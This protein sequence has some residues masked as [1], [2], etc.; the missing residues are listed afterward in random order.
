MNENMIEYRFMQKAG[1]LKN[2]WLY[3]QIINKKIQADIQATPPIFI[4]SS[5]CLPTKGPAKCLWINYEGRK[6]A[7]NK[8]KNWLG[9]DIGPFFKATVIRPKPFNI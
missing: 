8:N 1:I 6:V 7:L 3:F 4:K 2:S 9:I 5:V